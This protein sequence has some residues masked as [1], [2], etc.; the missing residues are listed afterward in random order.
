MMFN[1]TCVCDCVFVLC[2]SCKT[3]KIKIIKFD[4]EII[5]L[6]LCPHLQTLILEMSLIL[7]L[8]LI[9]IKRIFDYVGALVN[10]QL[11]TLYYKLLFFF[12]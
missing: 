9:I 7:K 1:S 2:S 5:N 4:A 11:H 3:S 6:I 12:S 10:I 8:C